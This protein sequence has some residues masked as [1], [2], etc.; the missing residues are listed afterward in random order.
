MA[1]TNHKDIVDPNI[2]EPKGVAA[3]SANTVYRSNGLGSGTWGLVGVA[4]LDY[5]AVSDELQGD[6]DDGSLELNGSYFLWVALDDVSTP[7]S[8]LV[9]ILRSSTVVRARVVLG[10]AITVANAAVSFLNSAGASMGSPVSVLYSSSAK[11]D[12]YAFTATGNNDIVGPSWI[13][14]ATD[15]AS[16]TTA[17]VYILIELTT[18]L[19]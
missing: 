6:I 3:A 7:S 8:V 12:S 13:E 5:T 14:V 2:H 10:N 9:P 4:N 15:G 18:T 17:P 16:T 11:G 19:N 1:D